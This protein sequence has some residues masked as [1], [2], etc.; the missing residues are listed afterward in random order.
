[1]QFGYSW[2]FPSTLKVFPGT[3]HGKI[4]WQRCSECSRAAHCGRTSLKPPYCRAQ[5]QSAP[6]NNDGLVWV[7]RIPLFCRVSVPIEEF[8]RM[9]SFI[10]QFYTIFGVTLCHPCRRSSILWGTAH[11]LRGLL[12]RRHFF[13]IP[14]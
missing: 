13:L 9:G 1:M 8:E 4:R 14:V 6:R 2:F 12:L 11:P 10:F 7:N 3:S 5:D